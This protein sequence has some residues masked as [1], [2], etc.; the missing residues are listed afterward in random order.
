MTEPP[1]PRLFAMIRKREEA[2]KEASM[3]EPETG[4]VIPEGTQQ[5][6]SVDQHI[7]PREESRPAEPE[8]DQDVTI[9]EQANLQIQQLDSTDDAIALESPLETLGR[10][11]ED[12]GI[13]NTIFGAVQAKH[14]ALQL[15]APQPTMHLPL[16]DSNLH[17]APH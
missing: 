15:T 7:V 16:K 14:D 2:H 5:T 8:P 12:K 4:G 17:L 3:A 9:T 1:I 11:L 10:P 13:V 6:T